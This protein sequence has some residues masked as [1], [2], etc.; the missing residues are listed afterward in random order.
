MLQSGINTAAW[1]SPGTFSSAI[2][3]CEAS[4]F[5]MLKRCWEVN[6]ASREKSGVVSKGRGSL[7]RWKTQRPVE[8]TQTNCQVLRLSNHHHWW[9]YWTVRPVY[10]PMSIYNPTRLH[11]QILQLHTEDPP[12][13]TVHLY[14]E[15][16]LINNSRP[17]LYHTPI[18]VSGYLPTNYFMRLAH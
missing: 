14:P 15:H 2:S 3:N 18:S 9:Q 11:E 8:Q 5:L 6:G 17:N 10:N 13:F 16:W 12:S 1:D 4:V 7:I